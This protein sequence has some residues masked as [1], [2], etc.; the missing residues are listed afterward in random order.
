M[1]ATL[2]KIQDGSSRAVCVFT[3]PDNTSETNAVKIDLNSGGT[4]LTLEDNQLGQKCTRVG[5]EKIWYSN[6]GMGVKILFKANAN[7]LAIELKED[8][9]DTICFKEF[10]A[11]RDSGTAGTNGDILFTTV[12]AGSGDTYTIIISFKK[13]YG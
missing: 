8:W 4:G 2:R 13:Y 1:A 11:L 3:N 10:T 9:S 6:V 12:G 7:E 5:I